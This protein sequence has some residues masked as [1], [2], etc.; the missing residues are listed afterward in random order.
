MIYVLINRRDMLKSNHN[1]LK[2]PKHN[3]YNIFM[4][5]DE[6]EKMCTKEVGSI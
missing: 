5:C 6:F 3:I 1:E 4:T 2:I